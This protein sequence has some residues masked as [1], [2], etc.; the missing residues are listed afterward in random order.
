MKQ[1]L[2]LSFILPCFLCSVN[3]QKNTAYAITGTEKG[4]PNWTEVRLIDLSTG[5]E[6]KTI[7]QSSQEVEILNA[8]TG[9]AVVKKD[10][11][12][13]YEM[14]RTERPVIIKSMDAAGNYQVFE[15]R[16]TNLRVNHF[17][18][19]PFST[20]SAA[21]AYDKKHERLYYTPMSIN[22][23]RYI[24]LKTQ[25]IY[26]FED[27]HFATLTDHWNVGSQFTRMVIGADGNGYA[28]T[29]DGNHLTQFTTNKKQ[30]ITDLGALTDDASNG[31]YSIHN[32]SGYGGDMVAAKSG[33]LYVITANHVVY[34]ID[35]KSKVAT[36][37]GTIQ[38][39]PQGYSTNGAAVEEGT[40]IIVASSNSTTGYYRFDLNTMVAEKIA[41]QGPVFGASDLANSNLI[42]DKKI[43]QTEETSIDEVKPDAAIQPTQKSIQPELIGLNKISIYP[44]PVTTGQVKLS[45]GGYTQ[46]TYQ[47]QLMDISGKVIR[48]KAVNIIGKSQV[49]D[50]KLPQAIAK[51]TY[52][53]KVVDES[54]KVISVNNLVVQ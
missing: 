6:L 14:L 27:E 21:M 23:L 20:K 9:K 28:L 33:D 52:V 39:L 13:D 7:Y 53:L 16:M 3:A 42:N 17:G 50:F 11:T 32:S 12:P 15:R 4:S 51:G 48:T 46:G 43:K 38:G 25:K 26:Y 41:N 22:Q 18:D 54:N 44:N 8:R 34:K 10:Q 35:V 40:K 47:V 45:F 31:R 37:K 5:E 36:Y 49:E 24:D 29:N 1:K 30:V 19:K 2:L